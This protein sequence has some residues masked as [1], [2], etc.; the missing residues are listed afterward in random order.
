MDK[1]RFIQHALDTHGDVIYRVALHM[2]GTKA[3]ADDVSQDVFLRLYETNATFKDEEHLRAWLIKVCVNRCREILRG[4]WAKKVDA[5]DEGSELSAPD[6]TEDSAL[7]HLVKHPIWQA[8]RSL[9]EEYRE[10]A[11]LFYVEGLNS[12]LCCAT[13]GLSAAA[14]RSRLFRARSKM[15]DYLEGAGYDGL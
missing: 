15:R 13:L 12:K 6:A 1:T 9:P 7:K 10:A 14:F 11:T 8:L 5:L 4:S 3:D 2:M